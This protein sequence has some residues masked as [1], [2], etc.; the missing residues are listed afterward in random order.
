[1]SKE[2]GRPRKKQTT[3]STGEVSLRSVKLDEVLKS[4]PK[5]KP[6]P[7]APARPAEDPHAAHHNQP[8][9]A[10]VTDDDGKVRLILPGGHRH[11]GG[12]EHPPG[13]EHPHEGDP[14]PPPHDDGHPPHD[15]HH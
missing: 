7:A 9:P 13:P 2:R 1:M 8:L 6:V 10:L 4:A 5:A 12:P 11:G 14:P 15:H 3:D